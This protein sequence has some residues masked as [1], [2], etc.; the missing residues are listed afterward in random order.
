MEAAMA[1]WLE[2]EL[3]E[4]LRP[5]AAPE[6][7]WDRISAGRRPAERRESP[8]GSWSMLP[9][10]AIVTS[11]IAVAT[12]WL[13]AK[14]QEPALDFRQL[15]I[16]ELRHPLPLDVQSSDA[17]QVRDWVHRKAGVDLS[18]ATGTP[19]C[20]V[21]A[22]V[23][24]KGGARI[25]AVTYKVGADTAVLLVARAGLSANSGHGPGTTADSGSQSWTAGGQAFAL[26]VSNPEHSEFACLLCHASL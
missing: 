4:E 15:A 21:G 23:I 1:D 9:I 2:L 26:A 18:P 14:G 10:A 11:M 3:A 16:Q 22:R 20:L 6:E 5:A 8:R 19:V 7:L 12:L 25:G 17:A 13:V 24:E